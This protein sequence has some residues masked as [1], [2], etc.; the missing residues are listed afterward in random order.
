MAAT[1]EHSGK[2]EENLARPLFNAVFRGIW[3]A[4]LASNIAGWFHDV[5]AQWL[6]TSLSPS[7]FAVSLVETMSDLPVFLLSIAAGALADVIDRRRF[8]IGAQVWM[9]CAAAGLGVLTLLG[10]VSPV[11]LLVM[12]FL[13]ASGDAM[14]GPAWQAALPELV[15]HTQL[16]AAVT[17]S[18]ISINIAR[19]IGP[20]V[21]GVIISFSGT[22]SAFLL[23][24]V[25]F[26]G[27]VFV[28]WRWKRPVKQSG[29]PS[30]RFLGAMRAG[31]RYVRYSPP[32]RAVLV[33]TGVFMV[34]ASATWA[35]L[36]VIARRDLGLGPIGYGALMACL[37]G[38]ALVGALSMQ[39][40]ARMMP[41]HVMM[42]GATALYAAS[43]AT[44]GLVKVLPLVCIALGLGG[45]GW[46]IVVSNLNVAAQA[47]TPRWVRAR[48][49][50]V[51]L[52]VLYGGLSG[53]SILWGSVA[54]R[55]NTPTAMLWAAGA[56]VIGLLAGIR[57]R[58]PR[59]QTMDLSP[60]QHWAPAVVAGEPGPDDGPVLITV[61]YRIDP[62][63]RAEFVSALHNMRLERL[64]DGAFHWGLFSDLAEPDKFMETFLVESWNEHVRQHHRVTIADQ[65]IEG[66]VRALLVGDRPPIV[67]HLVYARK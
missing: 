67:Q 55:S 29:L 46:V 6:M 35:L 30:E 47:A 41:T 12:T 33:R 52:L 64:R 15:P 65:T 36:P 23:N 31:V 37:G 25:S 13:L 59:E 53:G 27:V 10:H 42:F 8:L 45:I 34:G 17:L 22:A 19:V 1:A 11:V 32:L 5:A 63:R 40:I 14:S 50:S 61:E 16:R 49:M 38:G 57:Y 4:I 3:I 58:L 51:F 7:P 56:L 60:A 48:A 26:A 54:S 44:V 24:A 39:R 20:A 18:S 28:V 43:S 21:G 66:Q 2:V 9:M 62:A